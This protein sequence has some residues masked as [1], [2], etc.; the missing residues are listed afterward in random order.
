MKKILFLINVFFII[1]AFESHIRINALNDNDIQVNNITIADKLTMF[2]ELQN[3]RWFVFQPTL[4]DAEDDYEFKSTLAIQKYYR[5][6]SVIDYPINEEKYGL[7]GVDS[8]N[9]T[10]RLVPNAYLDD[11]ITI[12]ATGYVNI[13]ISTVAPFPDPDYISRNNDTLKMKNMYSDLAIPG[14]STKVGYGKILYRIGQFQG[15][16]GSWS[17]VNLDTYIDTN[18]TLNF[19]GSQCVQIVVIYEVKEK[20]PSI[21]QSNKYYH[22]RGVYQFIIV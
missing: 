2:G 19:Y 16:W 13:T 18:V 22:V 14:D 3:D 15:T 10:Q 21:F 8:T 9:V 20:A 6:G 4:D 12:G 17:Y 5:R 7:Y 11:E 1:F